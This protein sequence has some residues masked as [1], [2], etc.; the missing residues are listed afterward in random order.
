MSSELNPKSIIFMILRDLFIVAIAVGITLW[1]TNTRIDGLPVV[2]IRKDIE[3]TIHDISKMQEYIGEL[4]VRLE[5]SHRRI[6]EISRSIEEVR[7]TR[8]ESIEAVRRYRPNDIDRFFDE[9][10]L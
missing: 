4:E 10:G 6:E 2:P 1:Q 7:S 8:N 5:D 9:R 3:A